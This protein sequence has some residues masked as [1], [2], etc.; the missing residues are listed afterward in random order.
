MHLK[1]RV[2]AKNSTNFTNTYDTGM[3]DQN[4]TWKV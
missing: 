1:Y 3:K 4:S 2:A